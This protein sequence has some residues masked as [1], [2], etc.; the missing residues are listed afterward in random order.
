[1]LKNTVCVYSSVFGV[2]SVSFAPDLLIK[3]LPRSNSSPQNSAAL[4]VV[5]L[6]VVDTLLLLTSLPLAIMGFHIYALF[7]PG[8]I[9]IVPHFSSK[10]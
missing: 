10:N 8:I 3:N 5:I 1:M 7:S 4:V 2:L 9:F 6:S